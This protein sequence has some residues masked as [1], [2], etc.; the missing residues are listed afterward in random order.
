[1]T[2]LKTHPDPVVRMLQK[3]QYGVSEN[4][5]CPGWAVLAQLESVANWADPDPKYNLARQHLRKAILELRRAGEVAQED[6]A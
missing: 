3:R 4:C 1:M 2:T 6:G 5:L